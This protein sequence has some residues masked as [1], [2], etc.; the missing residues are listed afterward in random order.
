ML[1]YQIFQALGLRDVFA[2]LVS[3]L[4]EELQRRFGLVPVRV[5]TK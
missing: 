1:L 2:R 3:R 5:P 4:P